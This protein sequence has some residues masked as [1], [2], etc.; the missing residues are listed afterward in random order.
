MA[1]FEVKISGMKSAVSTEKSIINKLSAACRD[2]N[3]CRNALNTSVS[4]G[5]AAVKRNL[6]GLEEQVRTSSNKVS[7][8]ATALSDIYGAYNSA[9]TAIYGNQIGHA[10]VAD[11]KNQSSTLAGL[12]NSVVGKFGSGG[13]ATPKA[14]KWAGN[15]GT[16]A[17]LAFAAG[18]NA[19]VLAT[20]PF[21]IGIFVGGLVTYGVGNAVS[22]AW[23]IIITIWMPL[24]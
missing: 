7:S 13:K 11:A 8:M 2:I 3:A 5:Y 16:G 19:L 6:S 14:V 9:E 23:S 1:E 15:L 4:G 12:A 21:W 17:D 20:A 24:K 18:V 22:C 10:K